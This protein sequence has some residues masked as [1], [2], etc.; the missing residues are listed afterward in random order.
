MKHILSALSFIAILLGFASCNLADGEGMGVYSKDGSV[1]NNGIY[2][3]QVDGKEAVAVLVEK[4]KGGFSTFTPR[5]AAPIDKDVKVTLRV[6]PK[7]IEDYSLANN[8]KL[9]SVD[10]DDVLFID[11]EGKEHKGEITVTIPAG[12]ISTSVSAGVRELDVNK[13]SFSDKWAF[14]VKIAKSDA[15][16]VPLLSNQ[17]SSVVTFNRLFKT[18]AFHWI[19]SG[20]SLKIQMN[21]PI[22]EDLTEWTFQIQ[23]YFNR[24]ARNDC[25]VASPNQTISNIYG[26][27][28]GMEW[29]TRISYSGGIQ[30]KT[31]RDGDDTWT[32]K[33]LK[34]RTWM[35]ITWTF[36]R[37]GLNRGITSVYV[38]G[39]L[40]KSW[41]T[42]DYM[43]AKGT[44]EAGW[45]I[46]ACPWGND[47]IREAKMWNKVL[48]PA[49]M[50]DKLYLPEDPKNPN[51]IFYV[52]FTKET[53][54]F[55]PIVIQELTGRATVIVPK[56]L[57]ADMQDNIVFPNTKMVIEEEDSAT[58]GEEPQNP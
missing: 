17:N 37:T 9:K 4:N 28:A 14:G 13:Y 7:V 21:E 10:M 27:P 35:Q 55:D 53:M 24:L 45:S 11:S 54:S 8:L 40:Q 34:D 52:P 25:H 20:E 26:V 1:M 49:E 3:S 15:T 48:T 5:L 57:S 32:N 36:K 22:A 46:G 58:E 44:K 6:D 50:Q 2:M 29:Y 12:S 42:Q 43:W 30:L 23:L 33:P 47:Y 16:D 39:E 41:E 56:S 19:S 18:S 38:D 51:L 31:G